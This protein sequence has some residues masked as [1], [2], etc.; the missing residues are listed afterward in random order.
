MLVNRK[1]SMDAGFYGYDPDADQYTWS[2]LRYVGSAVGRPLD[3]ILGL[4]SGLFI[5]LILLGCARNYLTCNSLEIEIYCIY[6]LTYLLS[7]P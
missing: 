4:N 5:L 6:T 7:R 1:S 3:G 2:N